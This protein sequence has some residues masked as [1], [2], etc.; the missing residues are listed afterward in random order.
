MCAVSE[1]PFRPT[2]HAGGSEP[3]LAHT[4]TGHTVQPCT[5][6]QTEHVKNLPP[7]PQSLHRCCPETCLRG[8]GT[9][10]T[11]GWHDQ[12]RTGGMRDGLEAEMV[13]RLCAHARKRG[14]KG[15]KIDQHETALG[16]GRTDQRAHEERR[17][18][19]RMLASSALLELLLL[20]IH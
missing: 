15:R 17:L 2:G 6:T 8:R 5:C 3:T 4:N 16:H 10:R 11:E 7:P 9:G 14:R 1:E 12:E 19:D 18:G 20:N 13:R